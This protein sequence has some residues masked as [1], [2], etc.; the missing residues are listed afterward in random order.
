VLKLAKKR[1]V[2]GLSAE[3]LN[4]KVC[5]QDTVACIEITDRKFEKQDE[6]PVGGFSWKKGFSKTMKEG[7]KMTLLV[8]NSILPPA[9]KDFSETQGQV[10]ADYQNYLDSQ[11][12]NSLRAKYKVQVNRDVLQKVK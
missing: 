9:R 7:E 4:S 11:W 5:G 3:A 1:P 12:I 10:T 8:V 6:Q 2:T